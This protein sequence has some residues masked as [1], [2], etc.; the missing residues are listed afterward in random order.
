MQRNEEVEAFV[1]TV[2]DAIRRGDADAAGASL[3]SELTSTIGTDELEWWDGYDASEKAF[4]AQLEASGG[5]P[6]Q[7]D[8]VRGYALE[9]VGWFEIRGSLPVGE[10]GSVGLRMTGVLRQEP[11]GW[12]FLQMHASTG[13]PNA[14][15][16]MEGL[17]V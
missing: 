16:G 1:A 9:G 8:E 3:S 12:R 6:I 13:P 5:L 14:D 2:L 17:P 7:A 11:D 4:R 15:L 10:S